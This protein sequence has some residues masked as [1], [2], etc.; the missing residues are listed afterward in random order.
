MA[1]PPPT[2]SAT[3]D[4]DEEPPARGD[5]AA[6]ADASDKAS[7][8]ASVT[9]PTAPRASEAGP[10]EAERGS[11]PSGADDTTATLVDAAPPAASPATR[12]ERPTDEKRAGFVARALA[13]V[14]AFFSA[15]AEGLTRFA[16]AGLGFL[17]PYLLGAIGLGSAIWFGQH[18]QHLP[19]LLTN[20]IAWD[21]QLK[22]ARAVGGSFGGIVAVLALMLVVVRVRSGA[23]HFA[24]TTARLAPWITSLVAAPFVVGLFTP[25]IESAHAVLTLLFCAIIALVI[26]VSVYRGLSDEPPWSTAPG[27][28][29]DA[30]VA[31]LGD[32]LGSVLVVAFL[33]FLWVGYGALFSRLAITNHHGLA[34]RTTDLG[35]YDNIFY[36]SIHG[37]FLGC[38]FIKAGYHGSAHFDPIL[39]LLS[40]LYLVY[41]RAEFLLTLQSYWLGSA[42]VPIYLL[43]RHYKLSRVASCVVA[44]CFALHPAIHGANMYEFH[45]LTLAN[46]PILWVVY[47]LETNRLKAFFPV[48][49]LMLLVREDM[50]LVMCFICITAMMRFPDRRRVAA[51]V[52][53]LTSIVYF[54]ITKVFFMTSAEIFQA[55]PEAYSYAYYYEELT[56]N[57]KGFGGF[58]VSLVTNPVFVVNHVFE[59]AKITFL[60]VIFL[61][62]C[63]LPFVA[64]KGRF[65]LSY[66]LFF[67]MMA[68]RTAVFSTHFQYSTTIVPI[69]FSLVPAAVARVRDSGTLA[70]LGLSTKRLSSALVAAMLA[71]SVVVTAK[72]GGIVDNTSF[73]GGFNRVTRVL[74][75]QEKELYDWID[76]MSR[77]IPRSAAVAATDK[78]GPHISNRIK[79]YFYGDTKPVDYVFVDEREVRPDRLAVL[80]GDVQRGALVELARNGT[81]ALFKTSDPKSKI[82]AAAA[83]TAPHRPPEPRGAPRLP[84]GPTRPNMLPHPSPAGATPPERTDDPSTRDD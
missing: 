32:R 64:K 39:V 6:D 82:P 66:G 45:S 49:L 13:F 50:S 42:V 1:E 9:A 14:G 75:P 77:D 2:P 10:A 61:P 43:S 76:R 74:T 5:D 51:F 34:T 21:L 83:P 7:E 4:S 58:L 25:Q 33:A 27:A 15:G 53:I 35:Y 37:H 68:T 65:A 16:N 73:R 56:P 67:T 48:A 11:E 71:A 28:S 52:M 26:G 78:L 3:P 72:F 47:L 63:L 80:K 17:W 59:E 22:I 12:D 70:S 62:L 79:A 40:P 54:G 60:L 46:V 84:V 24:R 31:R 23:F 19:E 41:P 30:P 18:H 69:A 29:G 8:T 55:G 57:N 20:K 36:Q 44:A 81:Y 38:S